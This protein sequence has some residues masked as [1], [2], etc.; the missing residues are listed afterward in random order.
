MDISENGINSEQ[1]EH[2]PTSNSLKYLP[3]WPPLNMEFQELVYSIPEIGGGKWL[4]SHKKH[5]ICKVH[6]ES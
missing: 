4:C 1:N 2:S 3:S 5:I 6:M